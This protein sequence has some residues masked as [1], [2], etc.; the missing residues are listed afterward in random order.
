M[1]KLI[2][3]LLLSIIKTGFAQEFI[4]P[5]IDQ[6]A[7]DLQYMKKQVLDGVQ[8]WKDAFD[9]LKEAVSLD[10][11]VTPYAHV[12]RGPYGNPN[13]GGDD[14]SRGAN[15]AYNCALIWYITDDQTYANKAIEIINTWSP[16]L[17]DFD[18]NDAKLLAG[19]TGHLFCNAAEILRYTESGWQQQDIDSFTNMLMTVYYPLMRYYYPQANGNWDGAIIHSIMSIAIFTDNRDM[20]NNALN[21]F[22]YSPVNGSIFK[23]IYPSGQCQESTR[24]QGH[25]QLGLGEFAGAARVA[26]TQGIDLFSIGNNRIALGYEYTAKFILKEKPQAYGVI[27]ELKKEIRDDYEY[28]YRHYTSKGIAMP[29]SKMAADFIRPKATRSV[30]TAFRAPEKP[31]PANL[32]DLKISKIAYP[33]GAT[34]KTTVRTPLGSVIVKAGESLQK[35]LDEAAGTGRWVIAAAGVH[36]LSNSLQIPSGITLAGEGLNTTIFLDPNSGDRE[37]MVNHDDDL[38]DVTIRDLIIEAS[39]STDPLPNSRRSFNNI[40]RRGG[41]VFLANKEGQIKNVNLINL[42][43]QNSAYNGVFMSGVSQLNIIN[44]D[45][46]ENGAY[47][48]PGPR[49]MHN[50]LL[51]HCS[52]VTIKDSRLDTSPQGSGIALD[53]SHH[54]QITNCEIAR[55][56]YYGVV[57][58]ES[59]NVSLIGSLIEGNDRSGV[60]LEFLYHGS[61]EVVIQDNII[62]YNNGNGVESYAVKKIK[63]ANNTFEGNKS[64]PQMISENQTILME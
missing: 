7:A 31:I 30:L 57:I 22:L 4:H 64:S 25:V 16:V 60:M 10:F 63:L 61:Q 26:Y 15:L 46:S 8:P 43:V 44:C 37:T 24:D 34:V 27:S 33:A 2:V 52:E 14:L 35:A 29:F 38:H 59:T 11:V 32:V 19:W 53:H 41:I 9:R 6:T 39:L 18:Y 54:I 51:T 13:I 21:H 23:Y 1:K 62:H 45:F 58:A 20:F 17:W 28:I 3:I 40:G 48:V 36:T 56:G 49:L 12:K 42:T 55:N 5:G 47:M 50:L